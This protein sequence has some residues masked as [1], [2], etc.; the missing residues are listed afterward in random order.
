MQHTKATL[1]YPSS[2]AVTLPSLSVGGRTLLVAGRLPTPEMLKNAA[3]T[4]ARLGSDGLSHPE[5]KLWTNSLPAGY[6]K[7]VCPLCSN[8]DRDFRR[9]GWAAPVFVKAVEPGEK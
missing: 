1:P 2:P 5:P 7:S 9:A 3:L 8:T 6:Y 4:Q